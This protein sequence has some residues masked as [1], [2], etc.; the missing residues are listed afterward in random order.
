MAQ[1]HTKPGIL[2]V[3]CG[4]VKSGKTRELINR[5]DKLKYVQDCNFKIFKPKI[6][7]RD[8]TLSSRFGELFFECIFIDELNPNEIMDNIDSSTNLIVID[9]VQFF[10]KK[11]TS[12]VEDLLKKNYHVIVAGLDTDF[13]GDLF[14]EMPRLISLATKVHKLSGVCDF[15]NCSNVALR[16]Q[17]LLN[18]RPANYD[19]PLISIEG[20]D[21]N[22]ECRCIKH[23]E[24]PGKPTE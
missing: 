16:T 1:F 24:I 13:R 7:T 21:S 22:Y 15:P 9:E 6:D 3:Y 2:E 14:G 11:L 10:S 17:R 12:L 19:D 18:G 4:P 20:V 23:H 5:L 8:D